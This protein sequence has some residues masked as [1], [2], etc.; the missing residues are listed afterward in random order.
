MKK[1]YNA[2]SDE[3]ALRDMDLYVGLLYEEPVNGG[4]LGPTNQ[5]GFFMIFINI[6]NEI[7]S[8]IRLS[9]NNIKISYLRLTFISI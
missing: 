1:L 6:K 3:D 7:I 2:E 9:F 5:C 8:L 4:L